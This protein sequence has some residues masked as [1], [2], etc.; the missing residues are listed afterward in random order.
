MQPAPTATGPLPDVQVDH[1]PLTLAA[2]LAAG[3]L[4]DARVLVIA[5]DGSESELGAIEQALDY[6]GTPFDEFIATQRST[7]SSSD[8]MS[9]STHG[10]RTPPS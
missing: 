6:L 10:T 8:L 5:A 7:L 3:T 2:P 9:S 4:I 1:S